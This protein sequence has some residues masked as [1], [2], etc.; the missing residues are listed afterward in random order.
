MYKYIIIII[1]II[2]IIFVVE[3][4]FYQELLTWQLYQL[5]SCVAQ[6][7][8]SKRWILVAFASEIGAGVAQAV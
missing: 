4:L 2:I 6:I 1:I 3:L 7:W 5:R 8:R